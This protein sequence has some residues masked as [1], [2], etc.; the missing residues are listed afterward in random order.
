MPLSPQQESALVS[1]G[2]CFEHWHSSD[3]ILS[4]DDVLQYQSLTTVIEVSADFTVDD[5]W[6]YLLVD[7]TT[8]NVNIYLPQALNGRE[9]EVI[10][11]AAAYK[12]N[13]LPVAGE[14]IIGATGVIIQS[15]YDALRVKAVQGMG[16][17][18]I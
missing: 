11:A 4:H 18:A 15:K 9:I 3:R 16:W 13:I 5:R 8:G 14:T 1:G 2:D 6:D 7:T 17:I 12:L 10:K